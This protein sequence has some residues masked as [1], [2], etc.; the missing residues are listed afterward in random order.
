MGQRRQLN[1]E[2]ILAYNSTEI[3]SKLWCFFSLPQIIYMHYTEEITLPPTEKKIKNMVFFLSTT[4][5]L[6]AL[7]RRN[8]PP[9]Y[10]KKNQILYKSYLSW[11]HIFSIDYLLR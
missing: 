6:H 10:R 11:P 3:K 7:H 5:Y 8:Y 2:N 4:N 1:K 9:P